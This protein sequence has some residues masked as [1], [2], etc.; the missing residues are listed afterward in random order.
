MLALGV[1]LSVL[2]FPP[3][4]VQAQEDHGFQF[5]RIQYGE[6]GGGGSPFGGRGRGGNDMWAHDY[7]T[8]ELNLYEALKRTTNVHITGE[9]L[10]MTLKDERIFE[11]PVLYLCE[12]GYWYPDDED[13]AN[14]REYLDRGGFILFDDFDGER[15]WRNFYAQM[16]RVFPDQEPT[17]IPPNHS[18]WSIYYDIDPDAAPAVT[19]FGNDVDQYYAY[20][21]EDG[22][23]AAFVCFNQDIGDGWEWPDRNLADASTISFQMGIN[24]LIYAFTH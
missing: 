11:Y 10:V 12:P 8:A 5:V 9:N 2:P 19:M 18:V 6:D 3:A 21:T 24:F 16:K 1:L 22:R 20:F 15:D 13:I 23:M 4:P 14:L 17:Q 7:P